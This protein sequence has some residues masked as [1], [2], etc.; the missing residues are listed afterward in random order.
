MSLFGPTSRIITS[1]LSIHLLA[2][3]PIAGAFDLKPEIDPLAKQLLDD[4]LAVGFVVGIYKDGETQ[5]IGYGET[6]KGKGIVPDGDTIYEIGSASM[7]FTGAILADLVEQGRVNL[8]DPMQKYLPQAARKQIKNLSNITF[9]HLATHVSGLPKLPDDLQP[10]DPKNPYAGYSYRQM[11]TFLKEHELRR[12]PGEYEFSMYGMGLLGVL[13]AG[14]EKTPYEELLVEHIAIPCGM[15]DTCVKLSGKQRRRLAPPYDA[16]LR[17]AKNWDMPTFAG[18]G[19]IRST[20]NDM[21][22]FIAANLADDDKPL[23]KALQLSHKKHQTMPDGLSMGL[24]WLIWPDGMTRCLDGMTGG[25]AAWLAV[26]PSR[27]VGVVILSN[28]AALQVTELG[29]KIT[30]I[31][32]EANAE[33]AAAAPL[34]KVTPEVLKSYEGVYEITPQFALTITFEKDDLMV[35]G[36]GQPKLQTSPESETRFYCKAVDARLFFVA[37][38]SGKPKYLVLNQNGTNQTATRRD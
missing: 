34:A 22:K 29:A 1:L 13:M 9:G 35:Q 7:A 6:R 4:D 26:V 18:A 27:D 11:H 28:T 23:T 12:A 17:A 31:A 33:S 8:A 36:T 10:A 38:K 24:G 21:L 14:R 32:V 5:V 19:G 16:S 15:N 37:D 3:S 30:Q 2:S 25:Y 20:T